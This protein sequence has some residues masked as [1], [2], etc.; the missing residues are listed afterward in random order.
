LQSENFYFEKSWTWMQG[1]KTQEGV[2]IKLTY[3]EGL[4]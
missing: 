3:K 1:A 2:K 4:Q